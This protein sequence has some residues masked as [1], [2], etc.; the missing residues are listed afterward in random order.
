MRKYNL[1]EYILYFHT[2]GRM[3]MDKQDIIDEF[4]KTHGD[5]AADTDEKSALRRR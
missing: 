3:T 1:F 4:K 2:Q 5:P